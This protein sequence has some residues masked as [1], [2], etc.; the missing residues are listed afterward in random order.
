MGSSSTAAVYQPWCLMPAL[1]T[2]KAACQCHPHD[3]DV[4]DVFVTHLPVMKTLR[5]HAA[6][7]SWAPKH[8]RAQ[9]RQQAAARAVVQHPAW[10]RLKMFIT[11]TMSSLQG[12]TACSSYSG[13]G[14]HGCGKCMWKSIW[15]HAFWDGAGPALGAS[16]AAM[17]AASRP[18]SSAKCASATACCGSKARHRR[19]SRHLQP[20]RCTIIDFTVL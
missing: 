5:Q 15:R 20:S 2:I 9:C 4:H 11:W 7:A 13:G 1:E 8:R 18:A 19:S 12:S 10:P 17:C 16:A 3:T 6:Q 14:G